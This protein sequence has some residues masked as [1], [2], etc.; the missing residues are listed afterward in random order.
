M[1]ENFLKFGKECFELRRRVKMNE[2]FVKNRI[3][4]QLNKCRNNMQ[5]NTN[6]IET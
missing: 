1:S 3:V 6:K 2:K 5:K 4:E